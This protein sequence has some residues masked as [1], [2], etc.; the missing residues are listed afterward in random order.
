MLKWIKL[1]EAVKKLFRSEEDNFKHYEFAEI[2]QI[3]M[4]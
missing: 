3:S 1:K 2:D 4:V